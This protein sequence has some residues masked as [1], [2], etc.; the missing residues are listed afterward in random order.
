[1]RLHHVG[2]Y[3]EDLEIAKEFYLKLFKCSVSAK[4]SNETKGFSSYF[5]IFPDDTRIELMQQEGLNK[6]PFGHFAIALGS[7]IAVN[8]LYNHAEMNSISVLSAPRFTGDGYY[9]A[10]IEDP[11]GN[12]I[13]LTV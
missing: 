7:E 6:Q 10:V 12:C 4:Y 5:L 3:V 13:E 11:D 2:I 9:E 8:K 1:M